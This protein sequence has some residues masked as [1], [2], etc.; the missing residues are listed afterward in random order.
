MKKRKQPYTS[1]KLIK[2]KVQINL[3]WKES[4]FFDSLIGGEGQFLAQCSLP[5]GCFLAGTT[6]TLSNNEKKKI[7]S[8]KHMDKVLS[9]DTET[10]VFVENEVKK[11]IIHPEEE[12]YYILNKSLFVTGNHRVWTNKTQWKRVDELKIGDSLLTANSEPFTIESIERKKEIITVY[13]LNLT[14]NPHSFFANNCL[15]HNGDPWAT[16]EKT[17]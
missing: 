16:A 6:V 14:K 11:L 8:I 7:E 5:C 4:R 2:Q 10:E 3:F 9:Y 12:T 17:P 1:P 13:N 15:V